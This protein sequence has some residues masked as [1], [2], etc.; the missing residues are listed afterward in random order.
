VASHRRD[1]QPG[2][3]AVRTIRLTA[4]SA[5]AC[6]AAALAGTAA[7][8]ASAGAAEPGRRTAA[9]PAARLAHLYHQ[10]ERATQRYDAAQETERQLR[11]RVATLQDEAARGQQRVNDMRAGLGTLAAAQ[12]RDG[13]IDPAVRLMLSSRP[14]DYL[15]RAESLDRLDD[16]QTDDLDR[17]QRAERVL[18][19][20]RAEA[21]RDLRLLAATR[22]ALVH[23]KREIQSRLTAARQLLGSLPPGARAGLENHLDGGPGTG[24]GGGSLLGALPRLPSLGPSSSRAAVAVAAARS[25]IGSPY[26][27]GAAGPRAF[28]CSGLMQWSYRHAG[29][30]LPR[31]SQEQR[32]AGQH[33]PLSR[34]RPGDLVIYRSDASHV[35]M[36]V[37]DGRVVHA[38]YP[39]ARV[40]EDP[41]GMLPISA[42]TRP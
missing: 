33:V 31:T 39:G 41:V 34:I 22:T 23:R 36:Y 17:L 24:P 18:G 28:D 16:H 5:A 37:G 9:D 1:S 20:H 38:P 29:V 6:T 35:A 14:G 40:R 4:L 10:A 2:G 7:G 21:Q 42:V 19:Q 30:L 25:A 26:V 32:D 27:W 13:G 12:Y 15:D 8:A 11:R 3:S